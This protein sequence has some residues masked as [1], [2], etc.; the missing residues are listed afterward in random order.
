MKT[1]AFASLCCIALLARADLGTAATPPSL[2][3]AASV[4]QALRLPDGSLIIAGNFTSVG[5]V[6]RAGLAK[7]DVSGQLDP[8]WNPAGLAPNTAIQVVALAASPD[9]S[10]LYI[11]TPAM[12]QDVYTTGAGA[13]VAGFSVIATGSVDGGNSGI[14]ALAVDANGLLYI[15]GA[16]SNIKGQPRNGLARVDGSGTLDAAWAPSA[17]STVSTLAVDSANGLIYLGGAFVNVGGAA[18]LRIARAALTD[19][20]I[21]ATWA[22]SVSSTGDGVHHLVLSADASHVIF[23]GSFTLVNGTAR[24]GIAMV[25]TATGATDAWNPSGLT[26]YSIDAIAAANDYIYLGGDLFCCN[27]TTLV[28]AAAT[29][30]GTLDATWSPTADRHVRALVLDGPAVDAFGD[31]AY[32][33]ATP[34]LA[35]AQL[36]PNGS[37]TH[38]LPDCERPGSVFATFTE[39]SGAVLM[40]GEFQ[41]ADQTYRSSLLRLQA[42][43]SV[44]PA[45]APPRFDGGGGLFPL[46]AVAADAN[47]GQVYVGGYFTRGG[48]VTHNSIA[49]LDGVSGA[50][51]G[52]WNASI[53]A[54][55][56]TG[57]VQAIAIA[58]DSSVY[59]GGQFTHVNGASRSNITKLSAGGALD[60]T[61]VGAANGAVSRVALAGNNV[62]IGGAFLNPR[63]YIARLQASDGAFDA[64]WNPALPWAV[65][66]SGLFD[67]KRVGGATLISNQMSV[68]A[69]GGVVIIGELDRVDDAGQVTILARFD[70]PVFNVLAARD[71]G[72]IYASGTFAY[73]YAINN[74]LDQTP[75]PNGLAQIS[76]RTGTF[77]TPENWSPAVPVASGI[78]SLALLGSG[79]DGVLA[80]A[81]TSNFPVPREDLFLLGLPLGDNLMRDGFE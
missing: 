21:D 20:S 29:G 64:T 32:M 60:P 53:D 28:R 61:F 36:Q 46:L 38:L 45:F 77:G 41:K 7:I 19:G 3:A 24:S 57:S 42:D 22:P 59:V 11:A 16:F 40:A 62:Y 55:P 75:H 33:G 12:V 10:Q 81:I 27:Q 72:S 65:N 80:G 5:E 51:D 31:F 35:A 48:G 4:T 2:Y 43:A 79:P 14:R 71:D 8:T 78:P 18:H 9:G 30:T 37:A 1:I 13:N 23:S 69:F 68:S 44:D 73:Q 47:T 56:S 67:L 17:N 66:W 58:A 39:A 54:L 50:L 25:A 74:F 26:G 49:R 15:G 52:G 70:Q 34:V 76:L 6:A 63:Q